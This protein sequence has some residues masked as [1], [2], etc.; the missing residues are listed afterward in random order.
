[1]KKVE[2]ICSWAVN[3]TMFDEMLTWPPTC[4]AFFHQPSRPTEKVEVLREKRKN[5]TVSGNGDK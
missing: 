3:R 1:M 5:N 4:N 2:K